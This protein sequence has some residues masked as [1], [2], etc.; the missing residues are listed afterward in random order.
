MRS[1]RPRSVNPDALRMLVSP[2][3]VA[4]GQLAARLTSAADRD[5]VVRAALAVAGREHARYEA[6]TTSRQAWLLSIVADRARRYRP[7]LHGGSGELI[8]APAEALHL[9]RWGDLDA[10]LASLAWEPRLAMELFYVLGLDLAVCASV[11]GCD[12]DAVTAALT[13]ARRRLI[14]GV[15]E[16]ELS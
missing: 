3:L 5:R 13:A 10:A 4:M 8:D 2:H 15:I 1:V 11:M 14:D 12:A 9:E 7:R 16:I 6:S